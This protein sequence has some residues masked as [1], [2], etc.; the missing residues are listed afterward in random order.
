MVDLARSLKKK[1]NTAALDISRERLEYDKLCF[2]G[3]FELV[4]SQ[5]PTQKNEVAA[6][7]ARCEKSHEC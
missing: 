2:R 3:K 1:E 5:R 7:A 4:K 6:D